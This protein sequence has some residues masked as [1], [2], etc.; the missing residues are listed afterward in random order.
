[1]SPMGFPTTERNWKWLSASSHYLTAVAIAEELD[2]DRVR[3][4]VDGI[5]EL[6][7]ALAHS[8]RRAVRTHLIR[9]MA[10]I[11]LWKEMPEARRIGSTLNIGDARDEIAAI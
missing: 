10:K 3:E 9:L 5:H 6:V 7:D 4:A 8:E 1:M 2:A 11:I